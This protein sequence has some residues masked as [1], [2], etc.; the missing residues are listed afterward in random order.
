MK[1]VSPQAF[2]VLAEGELVLDLGAYL[3]IR[4]PPKAAIAIPMKKGQ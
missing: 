4:N 2:A 1:E 3:V